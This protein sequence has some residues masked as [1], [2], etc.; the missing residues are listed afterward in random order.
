MKTFNDFTFG[1]ELEFVGITIDAAV[2]AINAAGIAAEYAAPHARSS[3][4]TVC[5]D[6]SVS[7]GG[8]VVS[9]ILQGSAGLDA[10]RK[11]CDALTA[12]GADA[13]TTCGMHIH[14]GARNVLTMRQMRNVAKMFLRHEAAFD[15]I[16]P[17]SRRAGANRF[18]QRN[19]TASHGTLAD[20]FA[21]LDAARTLRDVAA[22]MNG[23]F[24]ERNHYTHH[25]YFALNFQSYASHGT[26]EFR[27]HSGTVD[28]T[29]ATEWVKLIVGFVARAT[30]VEIVGA[31]VEPATLD[32]LLRKTDAAGRR[33]YVARAAHF[34]QRATRRARRAA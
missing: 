24:D 32:E 7:G 29:K 1:V 2:R 34:A 23:G 12:A 19:A 26:L 18:C 17:P 15:Q 21:R 22:V 13:N 11:V 9:P 6:G 14:V 28:A 4:W 10:L 5:R 8:E 30:Q 31:N 33:F 20:K 27:Q 25:R 3:S 16:L